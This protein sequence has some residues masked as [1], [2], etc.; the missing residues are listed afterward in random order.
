MRSY[1]NA[2]MW[3]TPDSIHVELEVPGL[4]PD[5]MDLSVVGNELTIKV[6][7]P[8]APEENVTYHRRERAVGSFARVLQLPAEVDADKVEAQMHDGVLE[9]VLPKVEAAK[10]RKIQVAIAS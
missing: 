9:I 3:E 7:M 2:N 6:E 1:P 4:K 10:P 8:D 5:Q